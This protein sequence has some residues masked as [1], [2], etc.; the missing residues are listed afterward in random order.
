[1]VPEPQGGL[2]GGSFPDLLSLRLMEIA[3]LILVLA[4]FRPILAP[5]PVP[6]GRARKM[7]RKAPKSA[8]ETTSKAVS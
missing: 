3:I 6:T 5:R 8:P 4:G 7:V 2:G 1:M